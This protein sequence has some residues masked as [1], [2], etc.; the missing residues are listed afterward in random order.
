MVSF[1][2]AVRPEPGLEALR[3]EHYPGMTEREIARHIDEAAA[4]WPLHAAIVIHRVGEL[5][6]G[7]PIVLVAIAAEH[8]R[9]AFAACEFLMD[10]LKTKAPFWKEERLQNGSHWVAAKSSDEAAA[11]RWS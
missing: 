1:V 8:R 7:E 10:H 6:P 11:Q 4:R 3:L 9:E 5:R 2:G